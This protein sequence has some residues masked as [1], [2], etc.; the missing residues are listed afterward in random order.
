MPRKKKIALALVPQ[1]GAHPVDDPDDKMPIP[2]S[3]VQMESA[4]ARKCMRDLAKNIKEQREILWKWFEGRGWK[5][6]RDENGNAYGG[7]MQALR[8]Q[9][10][11]YAKKS[12]QTLLNLRHYVAGQTE[13]LMLDDPER[14]DEQYRRLVLDLKESYFRKISTLPPIEMQAVVL[15][16]ASIVQAE[17][18]DGDGKMKAT[19]INAAHE[20]I[21]EMR[22]A[23]G[24]SIGEEFI[25][26]L[27]FT[28]EEQEAL[29][30]NPA[31]ANLAG[32]ITSAGA[33]AAGVI[34]RDE[35]I[36]QARERIK[37]KNPQYSGWTFAGKGV[38]VVRGQNANAIGIAWFRD[39]HGKL[40]DIEPPGKR[41][42]YVEI[43]YRDDPPEEPKA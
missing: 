34:Q 19:H 27:K 14:P 7:W 8:D 25:A 38:G 18:P 1:N 23:G 28:P 5:A 22:A 43:Y 37:K 24:I 31:L 35:L 32:R 30:E 21:E 29:D 9:I 33:I 36:R 10:P 40:P 4:E 41:H 16:A 20:I 17:N 2:F 6:L 3:G 12:D 42:V 15:L 39:E 11:E 13:L 26:T